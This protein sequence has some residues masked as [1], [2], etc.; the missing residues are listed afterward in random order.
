MT[1]L[2]SWCAIAL[3]VLAG[4]CGG[5]GDGRDFQ[6]GPEDNGNITDFEQAEPE[7]AEP[8]TDGESLGCD[9]DDLVVCDD[10]GKDRLESCELGCNPEGRQCNECEASSTICSDNEVVTCGADGLLAGV[11]ACGLGCIAADRCADIDPSNGLG[12]FL[13]ETTQSPDVAVS[14]IVINTDTGVV[15]AGGQVVFVPSHLL[16][17][18]SGGVPVRV[19]TA[20][21]LSLGTGIIEGNAAAAFVSNGDID[22]V[23]TVT[24]AAGPGACSGF[25]GEP[26]D[27]SEDV[28][29][30]A[31]GGGGGAYAS[32]G[33]AGA[34]TF[35]GP[36]GGALSKRNGNPE[37]EPVR[38]GCAGGN[39]GAG[40]AGGRGGGAIQL[41]SRSSINV[42][43]RLHAPGGGGRNGNGGAGA[44][45]GGGGAILLEA[46]QVSISPGAI[47]AA[48]GG[49][50]GC[51]DGISAGEPGQLGAAQSEPTCGDAGAGGGGTVFRGM[52]ARFDTSAGGGGSVG[53]VRINS[54]DTPSIQGTISGSNSTGVLPLI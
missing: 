25:A 10:S 46:P 32:T 43:G 24:I 21:S 4:A 11:E 47:L 38:G 20:N 12:Q 45:G 53:R 22:V 30:N 37:L 2:R 42:T 29:L 16:P 14:G 52:N 27:L 35:N 3:I 19:F 15:R 26:A 48:N 40:A 6:D 7:P 33:G 50:G 39:G 54:V 31:G 8:C 36:G 23:G 18:P 13:D 5:V 51:K 44:G 9:G 49:A 1:S 17:A 34:T 41:V 28:P